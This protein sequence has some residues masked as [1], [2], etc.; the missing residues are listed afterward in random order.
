MRRSEPL[1]S[2]SEFSM[3]SDHVQVIT[4][5]NLS[6]LIRHKVYFSNL[7]AFRG[8]LKSNQVF[9][10]SSYHWLHKPTPALGIQG[11]KMQGH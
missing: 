2:T 4:A 3:F 8:R 7:Q 1:L 10:E 5:K 11:N 9:T 6:Q